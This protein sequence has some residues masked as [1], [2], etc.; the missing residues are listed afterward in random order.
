M[1]RLENIQIGDELVCVNNDGWDCLEKGKTYKVVR[2]KDNLHPL[3]V[4]C[5]DGWH[6]L[7]PDK[8]NKQF[9]RF[10]QHN[11]GW[12][13]VDLDGTL[14]VYDGWKG[15]YHIGEPIPA[16]VARVKAM[17]AAGRDVRIFTAR[18]TEQATNRDGTPHDL[19]KV[20]EVISTYCLKHLGRVLPITNI[21]DWDMMELWDD[22]CIQVRPNTGVSLADEL[23][24]IKAAEAKPKYPE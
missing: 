17:L 7:W 18:V 2:H 4:Q 23:E 15:P 19:A 8:L 6:T 12:I 10:I 13:G 11:G 24:A 1:L 16:M 3:A 9:A 14:A 22:R 20:R 5:R 21:K